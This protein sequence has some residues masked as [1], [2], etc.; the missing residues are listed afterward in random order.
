MGSRARYSDETKAAVMAALLTGQ[1]VS[2][3]AVKYNIPEGTV[4]S[5]SHRE[6]NGNSETLASLASEKRERIGELILDYLEALMIT[7]KA[8]TEVFSD[9]T[10]LSQQTASEAAVLHGVL[11]DKGIRLLEALAGSDEETKAV[12]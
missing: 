9:T 6:L 4:W 5:W 7:L 8:Q 1:S 3:I 10:W 2:S 11:A 12:A